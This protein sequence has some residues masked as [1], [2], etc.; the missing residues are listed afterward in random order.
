MSEEIKTKD[1]RQAVKMF[2]GNDAKFG[3][4]LKEIKKEAFN[5]GFEECYR[6]NV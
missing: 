2:L 5:E 3:K 4:W 1:V 6:G